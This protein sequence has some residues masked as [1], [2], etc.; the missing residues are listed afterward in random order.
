SAVLTLM[1]TTLYESSHLAGWLFSCLL[2][3]AAEDVTL[4]EYSYQ[5]QQYASINIAHQHACRHQH[6]DNHTKG[7]CLIQCA[8]LGWEHYHSTCGNTNPYHHTPF[9][10]PKPADSQGRS[11][12]CIID[13]G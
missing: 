7:T 1:V 8:S 11:S 13:N 10:Q 4:F 5:L 6:S 2:Q 9:C 3:S 12:S